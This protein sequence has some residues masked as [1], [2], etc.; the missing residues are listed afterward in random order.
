MSTADGTAGGSLDVPGRDG[1]GVLDRPADLADLDS[2]AGL[3]TLDTLA[4]LDDLDDLDELVALAAE[5]AGVAMA[6]VNVLDPQSQCQ[7]ATA[8]FEGGTTPRRDAMC[9]VTVELGAFV[10]VPD[11]RR[12]PRFA[13]SPWVDGRL[14]RVVFYASAPLG[15][16]A[17]P[18]VGT[19]CVFDIT[20]H[21]LTERQVTAL[22]AL[23]ARA[24]RLVDL[25]RS[26]RDHPD[27]GVLH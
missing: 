7:V 19:L 15:R 2:L 4:D 21:E 25:S 8:G 26:P 23:A 13:D 17:G 11:A 9:N 18:V 10:H 27:T 20:P 12:D 1:G 14:G 24:V 5:V 3:D 16:M 22:L 6:T